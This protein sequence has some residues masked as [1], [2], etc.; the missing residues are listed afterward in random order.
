MINLFQQKTGSRRLQNKST[1][2]K[3]KVHVA[4]NYVSIKTKQLKN[5]EISPFIYVGIELYFDI[6]YTCFFLIHNCYDQNF[7]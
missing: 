5:I 1:R 4:I 6:R 2:L 7:P 3:T